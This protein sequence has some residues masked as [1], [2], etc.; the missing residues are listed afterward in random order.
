MK[1]AQFR[2]NNK[3]RVLFSS[4]ALVS[5]SF[6]TSCDDDDPKKENTPELI[7]E[8]TLT[9]TPTGGGST[10]TAT[11]TDPDGEGVQNLTVDGPINLAV[12]KTYTLSLELINGLADPSE[13][14]YDITAEVE[15]EG[16]EHMFFFGWTNNVFNNPAGNGNIDAR[17]DAVNYNDEDDNGLPIGLSTSWTSAASAASGTFTVMLKHQPDLKSE[18]STSSTGESDLDVTFTINVD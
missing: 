17:A 16:D 3:V 1:H 15:E 18:T 9:F 8:V 14:E 7:T 10:V 13:P 2:I 4:L 5:M 12:D 11:A 6:L